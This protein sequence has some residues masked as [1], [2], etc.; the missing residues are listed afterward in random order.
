M[1]Q[2]CVAILILV[3]FESVTSMGE[4][5]K[6]AKRDIPRAVILSLVIQG[7]FCYALE[8]FAANYF[9]HNNYTNQAASLSVCAAG[10]HDANRWRFVVCSPKA[11]WWFMM[12]RQQQSFLLWS[13]R[14]CQCMSTG[15]RV[16]Y[17]MGRDEEL[18]AHFGM[19][20]GKRLTPHRAIWT[21]AVI[22]AAVGAFAVIFTSAVRLPSR[23]RLSTACPRTSGIPLDYSARIRQRRFP[24]ACS[25]SHSSAISARSCST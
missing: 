3:G 13:A 11:G 21:L 18:G 16:T 17:A 24:K 15:A 7:G 19:V 14:L 23:R 9:L 5:A 12:C 2:A 6:N 10:R 20:H 1:G 8:Y 22:S 4:E 25:S